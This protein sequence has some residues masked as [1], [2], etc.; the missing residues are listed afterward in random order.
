MLYSLSIKRQLLGWSYTL[1]EPF[2]V[3]GHEVLKRL[4]IIY[5]VD[6][7]T[8]VELSR[9]Q[10]PQVVTREV[11]E[12]HTVLQDVLLQSISAIL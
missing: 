10:E 7:S 6:A 11:A 9:L 12:R 1:L 4:Q 5:Y 3:L 8:P 2:A